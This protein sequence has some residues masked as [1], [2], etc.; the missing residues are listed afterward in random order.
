MKL[1][2]TRFILSLC[3]ISFYIIVGICVFIFAFS[4]RTKTN[5]FCGGIILL[6]SIIHILIYFAEEGY[7]HKEELFNIALGLVSFIT[8]IIFIVLDGITI[9]N[10]CLYWGILEIVESTTEIAFA[11]VHIK[12]SKIKLI[13]IACCITSLVLGILLCIHLEHGIKIHLICLAIVFIIMGL[14]HI[15]NLWILTFKKTNYGTQE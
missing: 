4:Q 10:V 15:L 12:K 5:N 7:K 6:S 3:L 2:K 1:S 11:L 13:D 8:G 9:K 14:K